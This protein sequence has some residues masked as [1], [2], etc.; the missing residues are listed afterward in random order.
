M[1][2]NILEEISRVKKLMGVNL[3]ENLNN[4]TTKELISETRFK[5]NIPNIKSFDELKAFG[6][7]NNITFPKSLDFKKFQAL[8]NLDL[9]EIGDAI[10]HLTDLKPLWI[11]KLMEGGKLYYDLAVDLY[12]ASINLL[13]KMKSGKKPNLNAV[14]EITKKPAWKSIPT[15]GGL[16]DM[17]LKF[18]K[19]TNPEGFDELLELNKKSKASI[20]A[21]IKS[22]EGLTGTKP[23]STVP[24]TVSGKITS[25]INPDTGKYYNTKPAQ[26][27]FGVK[28][29]KQN[30]PKNSP[31]NKENYNDNI[32]LSRA[33]DAGW[34]PGQPVPDKYQTNTYKAKVSSATVTP[35]PPT[36]PNTT[37]KT[38][39]ELIQ[40]ENLA[41][42]PSGRN[43][44][45]TLEDTLEK[46]GADANNPAHITRIQDAWNSGW[47]PGME[48]D[49]RYIIKDS[50]SNI[51]KM[52][53]E[54]GGTDPGT[55]N[56]W[57]LTDDI[58][59]SFG[60]DPSQNGDLELLYDAWRDGWRP[61]DPKT[62]YKMDPKPQ[63]QTERFQ[64]RNRPKGSYKIFEDNPSAPGFRKSVVNWIKTFWYSSVGFYE[65]IFKRYQPTNGTEAINKL[66]E[67]SK[68]HVNEYFS[69]NNQIGDMSRNELIEQV[70]K[71]K[72]YANEQTKMVAKEGYDGIILEIKKGLKVAINNEA[73]DDITKKS[74]SDI[75]DQFFVDFSKDLDTY[76]QAEKKFSE[77]GGKTGPF[78][79][80][81]KRFF[82][83]D[84]FEGKKGWP[85]WKQFAS[86]IGTR[87]V[88]FIKSGQFW[89]R[90][91]NQFIRSLNNFSSKSAW[92]NVIGRK[93]VAKVLLPGVALSTY[94]LGTTAVARKFEDEG[95]DLSKDPDFLDFMYD[96]L[97]DYWF[98]FDDD[99]GWNDTM[100]NFLRMVTPG[101]LIDWGIEFGYDVSED[102]TSIYYRI[103][104]TIGN[105]SPSYYPNDEK[106]KVELGEL[107][108]QINDLK[109]VH[110]SN[111]KI[112]DVTK[113]DEG[114]NKDAVKDVIGPA[115][116][117]PNC[118][119]SNQNQ[120]QEN[121]NQDTQKMTPSDTMEYL[122]YRLKSSNEKLDDSK[123]SYF[124]EYSTPF[125]FYYYD[126]KKDN[127]TTMPVYRF[128]QNNKWALEKK[129]VD[130]V[131]GDWPDNWKEVLNSNS[132]WSE[133]S[134]LNESISK[135][136]N[137]LREDKSRTKFG[138]DNFKHWKE[139]FEFKSD[140]EKNPGQY[141][142]VKINMEDVMDRIDHYRKK[143]DEDDAFVRAVIDTHEN[144]VKF[145]FTKD[146]AHIRESVRPVGL[147][148]VLS[149]ITESRGEKEIWSVARPANGNWFLVKG[150]FN[151]KQLAN[152]DLKKVE[153]KDKVTAKRENPE[154]GLKKKEE[155]GI[156]KL[157][158]DEREGIDHL[159]KKVKEKVREKLRRGWTTEKPYEFLND[160]YTES[161][162]NSV[163]NDKIKIYK[164]KATKGFFETLK[165]NSSKISITKGFCKTVNSIK[166]DSDITDMTRPTV[167]HIMSNCERKFG[168]DYGLIQY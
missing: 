148:H 7:K 112:C 120:N 161:E 80:W 105:N 160:F 151:R 149:I 126:N 9:S 137:M 35:T 99:L 28:P 47:R 13:K 21:G 1:E 127:P 138:E 165:D 97:V 91:E 132:G 108:K 156:H 106:T 157:R 32:K 88:E 60:V 40:D 69:R 98:T 48:I 33:W 71:L 164:L 135:I 6:V 70:L 166:N 63:F 11:S 94:W 129:I 42:D 64:T 89:T 5:L 134:K 18:Y 133:I 46:F 93:L 159:P 118:D 78:K 2:N 22:I 37:N 136:K 43:K 16:R 142:T 119:N 96:N 41:K 116:L 74:A 83:V 50:E 24:K 36:P 141:K 79:K 61:N 59:E 121:E 147:A 144:I 25:T 38:L 20:E 76:L 26:K 55:G 168:G 143:Y 90:E 39:A 52:M 109:N 14:S 84:K 73:M 131:N 154:D 81:Y 29:Y 114:D 113:Y 17:V 44:L 72:R 8:D 34:R 104:Y 12:E 117:D 150:D 49:P 122:F 65:D 53:K 86:L 107:I 4:Q 45:Y 82:M 27:D 158:R 92:N 145:M 58:K 77:L 66:I 62:G 111:V 100:F 51:N 130:L 163:F 10:K 162:I 57:V 15:E 68:R 124:K 146:L 139:T 153:P 115:Y 31:N 87:S 56:P 125:K 75:V 95:V 101:E 3:V 110:K 140:D 152:M 103:K 30:E 54:V 67:D 155:T 19:K 167:R 23:V 123:K 128:K 102:P 85:W